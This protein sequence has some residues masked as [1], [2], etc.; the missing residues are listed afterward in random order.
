[1]ALMNSLEQVSSHTKLAIRVNL[2]NLG[3]NNPRNSP[4]RQ[5]EPLGESINEQNVILINILDILRCADSS[6][7]T[8]RGVVVSSIELIHDQGC[9]ISADILDLRQLGILNNFSSGITRIR[10]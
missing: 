10:S 5:P 1:M 6:T 4:A 7:I 2:T 9:S 8:V 3:A